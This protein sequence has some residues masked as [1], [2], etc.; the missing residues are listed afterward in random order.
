MAE[1]GLA[2]VGSSLQMSGVRLS[3]IAEAVGTPTY[4]YHAEVIR[5][6]YHRLSAAFA[7]VSHRICYA[8]K[9]NSSLAILRLFQELGAGAD[10]VSAGEMH[11]AL[12]AGFAPEQLVFSGVGKTAT[13]LR[14][15][16]ET[17]VGQINVESQEE[18]TRLGDI[19]QELDRPVSL[20][21]RVN[22]DIPTATH[23]YI[24]TGDSSAKFGIPMEQAALAG[25]YIQR[26]PKLTL[27]SLAMH[28]GSQLVEVEPYVR[29]V[30]SLLEIN[31]A[32]RRSGIDTV[33]VVDV[34]GGF[35]IPYDGV[36][37]GGID[38]DAVGEAV[39]E[40]LRPTALEV[41]IEPGRFL[42]GNAGV[43]LTEVQY[44]KHAGGKTFLVLDCG[45][46][47]LLRPALYRAYHHVMELET[48]GRPEEDVDVVGPACETG[49]YLALG[50]R[51][52]AVEAGE[53]LAVLGA[54]AY[55]FV[56]SS[57]YNSRP[58]AAEVLVDGGRFGVARQR[59]TVADLL[60][61]ETPDPVSSP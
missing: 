14:Q 10:L 53:R 9:A 27:S 42:V 30:R 5:E 61:G 21:L 60:R 8:V 26:H 17:G 24:A 58:R 47:D 37:E 48:Q 36:S 56:M 43:L 33:N 59:E 6:Q 44:R 25:S 52:P 20:G 35:G 32:L 1:T 55:G 2:R 18:L 23:P 7:G 49:D 4:V 28:L 46:N 12:A 29:G 16:I 50:R 39:C 15:A 57:N 51:M 54:G 31:D 3:H 11:R 34:G 45:M 22:P 13:E 41:V 40:L 19:A 38:I